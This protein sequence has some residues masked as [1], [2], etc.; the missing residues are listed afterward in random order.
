MRKEKNFAEGIN[1]SVCQ[2]F[3][4]FLPAMIVVVLLEYFSRQIFTADKSSKRRTDDVVTC[5]C[6]RKRGLMSV[7][8]VLFRLRS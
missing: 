3:D 1:R 2:L 4:F 5:Y 8:F 7:F 6:P